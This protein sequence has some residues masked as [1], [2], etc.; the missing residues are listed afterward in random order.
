MKISG[1]I[2]DDEPMA[3]KLLLDYAGKVPFLEILGDFSNGISA[4]EFLKSN[5][6][7]FI[8]LDI[9]MPDISGLDLVEVMNPTPE[10]IFT[11]AFA[12]HAVKGFELNAIDY[13]LKPFDFKRFL[14]AVNKVSDRLETKVE[15]E[16]GEFRKDDFIFVKDGRALVKVFFNDIY[17]IK[18]MKDYVN[19]HT[20]VGKIMSLMNMKDLETDLPLPDFLRVHQSYIINTN[21]ISTISNDKVKIAD[22]HIPVSQTYRQSL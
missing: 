2:I 1:V 19:F 5:A 10:I 8:F 17:F 15:K 21:K 4:L 14:I 20:S 7:D 12:E 9:K 3:R 6:V 13:L 11:T 16:K 18:G 22:Q